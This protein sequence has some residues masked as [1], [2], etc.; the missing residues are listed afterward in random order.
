[1]KRIQTTDSVLMVRPVAFGYNEQTAVNN[2]FQQKGFDKNAQECALQEFD[3]FVKLLI[4]NDINVEVVYDTIDPPTPDSIFPNNWFSTHP[5]KMVLYPMFAENRR[6]ERREDITELVKQKAH[7]ENVIDLTSWENKGK[8]LEGTGSLVLDRVSN[9][10]YACKSPR[11][12]E[13]VLDEFAAALDYE[14]FLFDAKDKNGEQIYHTNVMMCVGTEFAIVCLDSVEN[15]DERV[16]LIES[17]EESGKEIIEISLEQMEN[18]AG[19][20]LELVNSKG[21]HLL[22]MSAKAKDSLNED[23]IEAIENYCT[24]VSPELTTIETNGGGSARC[25]IAEIFS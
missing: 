24:I 18:F 20:M 6:Y 13:E 10:A 23:Q 3:S 25:M 2:S 14:Y 21:N 15:I 12:N 4:E 17:L 7:I 11:T 16:S 19:N 5:G 1:M 8:F 22:I 9:I